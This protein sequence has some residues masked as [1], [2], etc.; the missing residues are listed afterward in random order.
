[1]IV[2]LFFIAVTFGFQM[3]L[4]NLPEDSGDTNVVFG[5]V[6]DT[7]ELTLAVMI[8]FDI[9]SAGVVEGTC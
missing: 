6:N 4:F 7:T 3:E 8:D 5:K 1:M 9:V 2:S